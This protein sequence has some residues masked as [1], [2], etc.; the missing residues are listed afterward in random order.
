MWQPLILSFASR[1]PPLQFIQKHK[2]DCVTPLCKSFNSFS[3][4]LTIKWLSKSLKI[5]YLLPYKPHSHS[6]YCPSFQNACILSPSIYTSCLEFLSTY[7][8]FMSISL[9]GCFDVSWLPKWVQVQELDRATPLCNSGSRWGLWED[10]SCPNR[11][12]S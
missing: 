6:L 9:M 4:F 1:V 7:A 3:I 11:E 10:N 8:G 12:P 5:P 2:S